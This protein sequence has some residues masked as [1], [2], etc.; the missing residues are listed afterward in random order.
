MHTA[1]SITGQAPNSL[2]AHCYRSTRSFGNAVFNVATPL[3]V[4]FVLAICKVSSFVP[5][6][7]ATPLSFT[8]VPFECGEHRRGIDAGIGVLVASKANPVRDFIPF[9]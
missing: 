9:K 5:A 6:S 3:S 1:E 8:W 4:T 7:L 2:F